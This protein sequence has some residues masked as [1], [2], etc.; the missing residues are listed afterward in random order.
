MAE[1]APHPTAENFPRPPR[2]YS[3]PV[4]PLP[5]GPRTRR[6]LLAV[7][8]LALALWAW[9]SLPAIAG[10]RTFFLR[11]V[12]TTHVVLKAF[13]A[14]ELA[15]GRIPAVNPA[16]GLGQPFRGNPNALP[17]YPGNLLYLVL[18]FWSAFNLHYALHWLLALFAMAALARGLGQ[19]PPGALLAGVTYAGSGWMLSAL[20]FYNL[21]TVAAWWPLVLLGAVLGGRRGIALGGIACGLAILGGEPVAAALGLIP[22]LLVAV[23][24]QGVRR[25]LA[26]SIAIVALGAAVALPQLV[27]FLEVLPSTVRGGLGMTAAQA[28][29]YSLNPWR[30]VE[31]ALPFPFGRP[32][33]IG[34][35]GVWAVK[36]LPAVPLFLTLYPGIVGLWL[37]GLGGVGGVGGVGGRTA[38]RAWAGLAVAALGIAIVGGTWGPALARLS[39]GLFRFPEKFLFLFALALPL[40]AGWGLDAALDAEHPPRGWRRLATVGGGFSLALAILLKLGTGGLLAAT[41]PRFAPAAREAGLALLSAQLGAWALT[42]AVAGAALV[43]A[44]WAAGRGRPTLVVA[45]QLAALA[46]LWPLVVT[47]RTAPYRETAPWARRLQADLGHPPAALDEL[48]VAPHWRPE[49]PYR[50]PPGPHF[51]AERVKAADLAAAPG[52]LH[53]LTYPLAPDLEGMQTL[54]FHRMLTPLPHRGWSERALWMRLTGVEAAVLF[55][56]PGVPELN[57]IDRALRY[58]VESRLYAVRD[59]APLAWRPLKTVVAADPATAREAVVQ[60]ADPLGTAVVPRPLAQGPGRVLAAAALP[61]RIEIEV[62]GAAGVVAVRRAWLPLY[63]AEAEGKPLATMPVN[64]VLLGVAVPPGRHRVVITISGWPEW[65]AAGIALLAVAWAV[66]VMGRS[67]ATGARRRYH[68][69]P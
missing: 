1:T 55:E 19:G 15:A 49:P 37:A 34:A 35:Q 23:E 6:D 48:T 32:A 53:G 33:W 8:A 60:A 30:L 45:L 65:I 47:D 9:V 52:L 14:R 46:Q 44:A 20:S 12:F 24:R 16:W 68:R 51:V 67:L 31:L 39:F 7:L 10:R 28:A 69:Q 13:G 27:A 43:A 40:L 50:F 3:P 62:E 59:P 17:Y 26:T 2:L 57:L 11:D 42:L 4:T 21:V 63:R 56:E 61:D 29:D 18:P 64:L 41:A 22:L 54:P 66:R 36:I 5:T 58:R 38:H 25:G